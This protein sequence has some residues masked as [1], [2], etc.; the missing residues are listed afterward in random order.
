MAAVYDV[1]KDYDTTGGREVISSD[2]YWIVAVFRLKFPTTFSRALISIPSTGTT[3]V[4]T[5]YSDAVDVRG[6]PLLLID[7]CIQLQTSQSKSSYMGSM[8]A[9]LLDSGVN[10][11]AEIYPG[12]YVGA[13]MFNNHDD[14]QS[15]VGRLSD[16]DVNGLPC[17]RFKDGLKFLGRVQSLRKNLT[18]DPNGPRMVRYQL[19]AVSFEAFDAQVFYDPYLAQKIPGVSTYF[20]KLDESLTK[21][22]QTQGNAGKGQFSGFSVNAAVPFFL[23]LLLGKGIPNQ[24]QTPGPEATRISTGLDAPYSYIVPSQIGQL[25][26][27]TVPSKTI[28]RYTDILESTVGVQQYATILALPTAGLDP[29][30]DVPTDVD[31]LQVCQ[32][33]NV[34]GTTDMLGVFLPQIPQ[35]TNKSVW[36]VLQQYLNPAVNELYATL[37][38]NANGDVL[39]TLVCRQL[40]FTSNLFDST[41]LGVDVTRFLDLPRWGVDPVLVKD[42]NYGRSDSLR[43]N[44]VHIYGDAPDPNH[45]ITAQLVQNPPIRDD[46]D[47]AR[48]GLRSFMTTIQCAPQD[49]RN[50]S[51]GKWMGI[52]SDILMSQQLALTGVMDTFGIQAPICV[53]DNLEWDGVVFHLESVSHVC[54]IAGGRKSFTTQLALSHGVSANPGATDLSI[55]ANV[56][57]DDQRTYNPG[58]TDENVNPFPDQSEP[59][60]SASGVSSATGQAGSIATDLGNLV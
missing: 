35:F 29:G 42:V 54:S 23:E 26:G 46:L 56:N 22:I 18:Q 48:S 45:S 51:A 59:P 12:D 15:V 50:G 9:T 19:N 37:R 14:F 58:L 4:S 24:L 7:D 44:F 40:P 6:K 10:Y 33:F 3:S 11:L 5:S 2:P 39:P 34:I 41:S 31:E 25:L 43:F 52:A 1:I 8:S 49:N 20:A 55:Y 30:T 57:Q 16:F 60:S 47:V 32:N 28:L 17:N 38:V 27:K 21:L 53:G 13:W 36:S